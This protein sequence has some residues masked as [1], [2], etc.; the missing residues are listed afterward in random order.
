[1]RFSHYYFILWLLISLQ[2]FAQD[3]NKDKKDKDPLA[4]A[5]NGLKFRS[6]GPA[7]TSGRIA[8]F[9]VN[10]QNHSE[11]Y[12]GIA[13]GNIWKTVNNGTT[14]KPV[15][16]KY[17]AYSIG[18]LKIDSNNPSVVWA[19]TGENN[20]QRSVSYGDGIYKTVDGGKS[21]KNMGL[22]ESRQIGM[23]AID[24]RDSNIIFVAA[25][26][27][28]W[29][30]GGDRGLYKTTDGGKNW[31][32][33]LNI[34]ENTGVNNVVIDPV[35]PDVM[36]ATS[37][38]RRRHVNIRIGGGPESNLYKST[39]G[40]ENW[41]KITSGLPKVD[42]GGMGIDISPIDH[43]TVYLMVEAAMDKGG[44]FRSTDQG[45]SWQKMSK[46]NTSG[47]YFGEIDCDPKDIN[48]IYAPE[49]YT[50]VSH[51]AGK[52]WQKMS[53]NKRHV[54]DHALWID[55]NDTKHFMIGGDGG[56][57]ETFDSG[58]EFIHKTNLPV[59]QFYRINVDMDEPFYN[60]YGG[61]QDNNSFGGPSQ[62]IY[63][64]GISNADWK[65]T[66][67]G[68]GYWQ[69]VDPDDPN[70]VYSE[71]QYGNLY[72]YDKK[73]GER[74][75]IKPLPNKD[76]NT[77]KWNW[78][79][80]FILSPH[81]NHRLYIAGNKVYKSDDRGNSWECISGDISR[82][83]P[84]DKWPVMGRY[85]SVDAVAK[86]VST[87]LYGMAV[88]LNESEIQEGLLYVGTDDGLIQMTQNNGKDWQ[89]TTHFKTVPEYTYVS[90]IQ[91]SKHDANVVFASFDNRKRDDF[92]PYL[93]KSTDKGKTWRS[94]SNNLPENGT[95]HTIEQDPVNANL[96]FVGTEFGVF[97]SVNGGE[98]WTQLKAGLPTIS[99]RDMVIHPRENDLILGTFGRGIYILDDYS[100]LRVINESF[101]N[102]ESHLFPVKDALLYV[103][104]VRGN[105]EGSMP[106]HAKNRKYGANFYLYLKEVPKNTKT[107]RHENEKK[108][109][110]SKSPI[111]I[112]TPKTLFDEKNELPAY[113]LITISDEAGK[114]IRKLTQKPV[115]GIQTINWNLRYLWPQPN[116]PTKKFDPIKNDKGGILVVPGK[117]NI[118]IDLIDQ[119]Q[120]KTLV[121][122][123]SFT[124][125]RLHNTSLPAKDE[126]ALAAQLGKL[127]DLARVTW[128]VNALHDE[129]TQK[130]NSLQKTALSYADTPN[131]IMQKL[132]LIK[133]E[134]HKIDWELHGEKPIAS[135]EETYP[136]P[137]AIIP[138]L[139]RVIF[140]HNQ[141][142]GPITQNEI[143]NYEI[144]KDQLSPIVNK[145]QQLLENDIPAIEQSFNQVKAPWT[146][147]RLL[148]L[149]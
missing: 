14:F 35:N 42:K 66:L 87:S 118:H 53:T 58:K 30:P 146:S 143:Q 3:N 1:M 17:G 39:D 124:V 112:P 96:L 38:Q 76:E 47:Q 29:G 37:E 51:D 43:N 99:V 4:Q 147:G 110:K 130:V 59:A 70:T 116:K 16:D 104:N 9:A 84:R 31:K 114:V 132:Q 10:P 7:F 101:L 108:L 141:S 18:C 113:L 135:Y 28:V 26:G 45:E 126:A 74:I 40:G 60:I 33:V 68:D 25:E 54:D 36:Y 64:N 128:G 72:R 48:T 85:W 57:Y 22:K 131:N 148:K 145:I 105:S 11:Y 80:P 93:L 73:S 62:T 117:Y 107:Q 149:D 2:V 125:K 83:L 142:T 106:Y 79:T 12:V 95:V 136:A 137:M 138:R 94:I 86:N 23:I 13:A 50:K 19:G 134:L 46:Y 78:N 49:T 111:P 102:K 129:L 121:E 144:I 69:A 34:S 63:T 32:K 15:F 21:W 91:A 41:R 139:H 89:T 92:K 55:P 56:I 122:K 44:F 71:Y 97:F 6:I 119:N 123:E 120:S 100:P 8:D 20:H 88:S 75:A 90:D 52:T 67:G 61:T 82:N 24:P 133:A 81:N 109:I 98:K 140:I 127:T 115:N 103:P 65:V 77:I 5:A 27:S